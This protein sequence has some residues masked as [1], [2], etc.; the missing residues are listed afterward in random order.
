MELCLLHC[1]MQLGSS[2]SAKTCL[3]GGS[4]YVW[5]CTFAPQMQN[6]RGLHNQN[7]NL[8]LINTQGWSNSISWDILPKYSWMVKY[9]C[10]Y[11]A[12][13]YVALLFHANAS[14]FVFSPF[15]I[16]HSTISPETAEFSVAGRRH[17]TPEMQ[18]FLSWRSNRHASKLELC[19]QEQCL[20]NC[21]SVKLTLTMKPWW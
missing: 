13:V 20:S 1:F 21:Y 14:I 18:C 11:I 12:Y 9:A 5:R 19:K 3:D 16:A 17:W 7:F 6:H 4:G 8:H 10:I 15:Q 2:K